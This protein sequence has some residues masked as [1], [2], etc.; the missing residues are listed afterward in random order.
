[1]ELSGYRAWVYDPELEE[2]VMKNVARVEYYLDTNEVSMIYTLATVQRNPTEFTFDPYDIKDVILMEDTG[3][4]DK[5][6][7]HIY[8]R[9]ILKFPNGGLGIVYWSQLYAR[10]KIG[11]NGVAPKDIIKELAESCTVEGNTMETTDIENIL[12]E[13]EW[14]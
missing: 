13:N 11:C 14:S 9:D 4:R 7:K 1:M 3:L 12:K 5:R 8:T 2:Y 6:G 10:F